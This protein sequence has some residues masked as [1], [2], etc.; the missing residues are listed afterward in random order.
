MNEKSGRSALPK[1]ELKLDRRSLL[2]GA[3]LAATGG[4]YHLRAPVA[5]AEPVEQA[6]FSASIPNQVAGW[7]SRKTQEVVLP[8]QD[9]SNQ[10]Y[11]N[12][13]TRI[14]EGTGLPAIMLLI[15]YSSKQQNDIQ[16]HRPEVCYPAAG[17]PILWNRPAHIRLASKTIT[18]RE[19]LAD[20]GALQERIFYWV[21]VGHEFPISWWQQRLT[22]A[23]QNLQGMVPDG[24]LFRV[25]A[26][27]EPDNPVSE[28]IMNFVEAF[29][30]EVS[31]QF[32]N[33]ILL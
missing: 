23:V 32:R 3:G 9:E 7:T 6:N 33:S 13:E 2:I 25:S 29:V 20:R 27:E 16:V 11:Q 17:F 28:T 21:R 31:P 4:L 22:M 30:M 10:L 26:I 8:P 24:A 18:G 15:A 1:A 5:L 14:Y 12:L 19:L